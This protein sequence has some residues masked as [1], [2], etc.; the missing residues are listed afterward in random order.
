MVIKAGVLLFCTLPASLPA[1]DFDPLKCLIYHSILVCRLGAQ[2]P[3]ADS[4]VGWRALSEMRMK[5]QTSASTLLPV[6]LCCPETSPLSRE[7]EKDCTAASK[8]SFLL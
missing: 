4:C 1:Q 2:L 6:P 7:A 3:R 8:V 5:A